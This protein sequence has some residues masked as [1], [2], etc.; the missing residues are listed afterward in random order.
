VVAAR[1]IDPVEIDQI[2]EHIW[3]NLCP[4]GAP[5][6]ISTGLAIYFESGTGGEEEQQ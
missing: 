3:T 1:G 4:S 6:G 5:G 2:T